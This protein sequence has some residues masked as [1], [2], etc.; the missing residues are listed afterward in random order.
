MAN[1]RNNDPQSYGSQ[2]DGDYPRDLAS[3]V[4]EV[5]SIAL[6]T[7][8]DTERLR[9]QMHQQQEQI[10]KLFRL[11]HKQRARAEGGNGTTPED[12]PEVQLFKKRT[13]VLKRAYP[14]TRI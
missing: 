12:T 1:K 10:Q 13:Q 3:E 4:A 6:E 8:D 14:N 9:H 2:S 7:E 11:V 5:A